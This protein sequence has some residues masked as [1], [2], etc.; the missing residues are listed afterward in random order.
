MASLY[1]LY[2]LYK[3]GDVHACENVYTPT[4]IHIYTN[5]FYLYIVWLGNGKNKISF[6]STSGLGWMRSL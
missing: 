1:E 4:R 5:S 3:L 6:N 2:T